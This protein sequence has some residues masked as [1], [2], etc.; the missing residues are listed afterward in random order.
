MVSSDKN[1]K[2]CTTKTESSNKASYQ[3]LFGITIVLPALLIQIHFLL[4]LFKSH[5]VALSVSLSSFS[6]IFPGEK[7]ICHRIPTSVQ[8]KNNKK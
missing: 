6:S 1:A 3:K 5:L 4:R 7:R 8:F 2:V